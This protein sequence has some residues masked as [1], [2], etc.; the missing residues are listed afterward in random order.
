LTFLY[1]TCPDVCPLI[2]SNLHE[3]YKRLGGQAANVALVAVTV[4]PVNDTVSQV[5]QF[6]DQHALSDEWFFLT[7]S[8]DQLQ[9]VWRSYG[10]LAQPTRPITA[11]SQRAA[12]G[13]PPQP[14]DIDP[15]ASVYLIDKSGVMRAAL[16]VDVVPDTACGR[17]ESAAVG[18]SLAEAG[19]L[20]VCCL[21]SR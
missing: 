2:A 11:T 19:S 6:S 17:P 18:E 14:A 15:S 9:P 4:D 16:P 20:S 12:Q 3:A 21:Y 1:T 10:I 8:A 5:R 7:G 13:L